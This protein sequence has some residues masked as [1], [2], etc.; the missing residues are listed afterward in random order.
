MSFETFLAASFGCFVFLVL[1]TEPA[2]YKWWYA[3]SYNYIFNFIYIHINTITNQF[4]DIRYIITRS[5]YTES[6]AKS[7]FYFINLILFLCF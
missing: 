7:M 3:V 2:I 1:G 4:L 5:E 6:E